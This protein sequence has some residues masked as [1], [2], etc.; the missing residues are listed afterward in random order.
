MIQDWRRLAKLYSMTLVAD[1]ASAEVRG[2]SAGF[3]RVTL[4]NLIDFAAVGAVPVIFA[5]FG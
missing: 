5:N 2:S 1:C 3:H 4:M